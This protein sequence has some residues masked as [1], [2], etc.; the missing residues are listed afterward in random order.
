MVI[1]AVASV[2]TTLGCTDVNCGISE[3]Q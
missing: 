3:I 2:S 1:G